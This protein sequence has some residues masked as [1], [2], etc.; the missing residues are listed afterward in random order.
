[1][2]FDFPGAIPKAFAYIE[3]YYDYQMKVLQYE[4]YK[5]EVSK[6]SEIYTPISILLLGNHLDQGYSKKDTE[7]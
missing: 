6:G 5:D 2:V 7:E 4:L 3:E 1:M